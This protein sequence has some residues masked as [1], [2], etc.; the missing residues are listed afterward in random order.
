MRDN[1]RVD[2]PPADPLEHLLHN[3]YIMVVFH[4]H[5]NETYTLQ[6]A[7]KENMTVG[8]SQISWGVSGLNS[9]GSE[10]KPSGPVPGKQ[11]D[12]FARLQA[13]Q[14]EIAGSGKNLPAKPVFLGR[15]TRQTPTVSHLLI[16]GP[17]KDACWDILGQ[18]VNA[19][20]PFT[21]I[22][23]GEAIYMNPDTHEIL[24]GKQA[25]DSQPATPAPALAS[26]K[27][28]PAMP[29]AIPLADSLDGAA[30]RFMGIAYERMNCYELVVAGLETMGVQYRGQEGLGRYLMNQAVSDGMAVNRHLTGEGVTRAIGR[31]LH[32]TAFNQV[33][34]VDAAV[35]KALE[36]LFE[37]LEPGQILSFSTP[38]RGH[39]GI[40]SRQGTTWTFINAGIMDNLVSGR[41]G[42]KGV[43]EE[44]LAAEIRNW[45]TRAH[46]E[47]SGLRITL[48]TPDPVKLARFQS[49]QDT[50]VSVRA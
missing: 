6:H 19:D 7:G 1:N 38:T 18:K 41:P 14:A 9:T 40:I 34:H 2:T 10:K 37:K 48:G 20:K 4:V 13:S 49:G 46:R 33:P 39:T 21:R 3:A 32:V 5:G 50:G 24:W 30:A 27:T 12:F 11:P 16:Q 45:V 15:V 36:A 44:R 31:D 22:P 42:G 8:S 26:V 35:D 28:A 47:N 29:E 23:Q 43:G 17:Y 25:D